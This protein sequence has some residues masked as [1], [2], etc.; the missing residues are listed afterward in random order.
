MLALVLLC[1]AYSISIILGISTVVSISYHVYDFSGHCILF[2]RGRYED[3]GEFTPDWASRFHCIFPLVVAA[4]AVVFATVKLVKSSMM[5]YNG[6]QGK[7]SSMFELVFSSLV[8]VLLSFISGTL[9]SLGFS[10]WCDAVQ[11]R[12]SKGCEAAAASMTMSNNS[13]THIVVKNFHTDL[14][15]GQ[16]SVWSSLVIWAFI[17]TVSGKML[18]EFHERAYIRLSMARERRRY[19]HPPDH[20]NQPSN[21]PRRD[22]T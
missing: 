17:L 9:V 10:V 15:T 18:F 4:M 14:V 13:E 16:F 2:T 7:F 11:E 3:N 6:N 22:I 20:A 5:L 8:M 12:F 1:A 19:N 21:L